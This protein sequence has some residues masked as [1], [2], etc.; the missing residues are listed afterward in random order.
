[1]VRVMAEGEDSFVVAEVVDTLCEM[2][3]DVARVREAAL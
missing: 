3:A 1:L 2:I